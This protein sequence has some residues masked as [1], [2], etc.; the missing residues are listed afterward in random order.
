M[1]VL[2]LV[3]KEFNVDDQRIYLMGHSQGGGGARH[4]AEKYLD[5]WQASRCWRRHCSTRR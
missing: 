3:R 1:N 4:L 2:A 5:T